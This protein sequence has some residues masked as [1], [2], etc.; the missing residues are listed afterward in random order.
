[1]NKQIEYYQSKLE[2]EMDAC[3]LYH[4]ME[5]GEGFVPVDTRKSTAFQKEHIPGA[6]NLWQK[7]MDENSTKGLDRSKTYACYCKG[8]GCNAS[9]KGALK[10]AK[11]GFKVIEVMGGLESWKADGYPTEGTHSLQVTKIVCAC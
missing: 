3:D 10:L 8:T 4:A 1:M 2:Y 11:L 9:T 6:I 5:K 7:E